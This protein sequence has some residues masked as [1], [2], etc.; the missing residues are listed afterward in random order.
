MLILNMLQIVFGRKWAKQTPRWA[1]DPMA[2]LASRAA[3]FVL[4]VIVVT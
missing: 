4:H 2:G 1:A 3:A